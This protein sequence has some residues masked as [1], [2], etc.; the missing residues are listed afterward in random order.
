M[1]YPGNLPMGPHV[2]HEW[3]ERD[4]PGGRLSAE[5]LALES[6]PMVR[7]I[8]DG[9]IARVPRSVQRDALESAGLV[10]LT[11]AAGAFEPDRDGAFEV[12]AAARIR[13]ALIDVVRA[14]QAREIE[15]RM[16]VEPAA[17]AVDPAEPDDR[18]V[19]LRDAIGELSERHRRVVSRYFVDDAPESGI[20]AELGMAEAQVVQLRTEALMLLRDALAASTDETA[21]P[22]QRGR[23]APGDVRRAR[24]P[25]HARAGQL[26]AGDPAAPPR[27]LSP[28]RSKTSSVLLAVATS[29]PEPSVTIASV[30]PTRE[31]ALTT[32]PVAVSRPLSG[33]HRLEVA[34]LDLD[35]GVALALRQRRVEGA[36]RRR[37]EQRADQAAVHGADRVV[38]R[39]VRRAGEDGTADLGLDQVELHRRRDRRRRQLALHHRLHVVDAGHR[40]PLQGAR[41]RVLPGDGA[42]ALASSGQLG[43]RAVA[44]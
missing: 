10:A 27:G 6:V 13:S 19:S 29:A 8:V 3:C 37:V 5:E 44:P 7:S 43:H 18:L 23:R 4:G 20:A 42:G 24:E 30:N 28:Y 26:D 14:T 34:D 35:R 1:D 40:Q 12:Y 16:P 15:A 2:Q 21:E 32:V 22:A 11:E 31:P 25:A 39:L 9:V 38:D 41:A 33:A 17:P 36:A